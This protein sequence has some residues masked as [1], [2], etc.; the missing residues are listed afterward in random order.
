MVRHSEAATHTHACTHTPPRGSHLNLAVQ[1]LEKKKT[2]RTTGAMEKTERTTEALENALADSKQ[3]GPTLSG[4][5]SVL[6]SF[7]LLASGIAAGAL[8][9][10]M[11]NI[12]PAE[13]HI[14][15]YVLLL[16]AVEHV[17]NA[18]AALVLAVS[19]GPVVI[20]IAK[21]F[22]AM[23]S[24]ATPKKDPRKDEEWMG[25]V[26]GV[27]DEMLVER[28]DADGVMKKKNEKFKSNDKDMDEDQSTTEGGSGI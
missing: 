23:T 25:A 7:G 22:I 4:L 3:I 6:G 11:I 14:L 17:L 20:C 2:E 13:E 10:W 24:V 1:M 28:K 8:A 12:K 19:A 5:G 16:D 21:S 26:Q 15:E 9:V 18:A 27:A